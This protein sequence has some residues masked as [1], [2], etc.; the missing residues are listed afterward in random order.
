MKKSDQEIV[1][2]ALTIWK[3][4]NKSVSDKTWEAIVKILRI[5]RIEKDTCVLDYNEKNRRFRYVYSGVLKSE[6]HLDNSSFINEF[7]V[8]PMPYYAPISHIT[9]NLRSKTSLTSIT[10]AILIEIEDDE[11]IASPDYYN[12][13]YLAMSIISTAASKTLAKISRIRLLN[14]DERYL[15][16]MINK[17]SVL[18]H[19][20]QRDIASFLN[21]SPS[22][23]SRIRRTILKKISR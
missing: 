5:R 23:L 7:V 16:L 14:A 18:E 19:A 15:D 22:S 1:A 10:P 20:K 3:N 17:P 6:Y 9:T 21:I 11:I 8:G 13:Q 12:V 4:K 2:N